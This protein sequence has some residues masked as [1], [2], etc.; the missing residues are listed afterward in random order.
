MELVMAGVRKELRKELILARARHQAKRKEQ[1]VRP[2]NYRNTWQR[3]PEAI[4]TQIM[5]LGSNGAETRDS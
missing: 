3:P 2:V 1:A 4:S 5:A